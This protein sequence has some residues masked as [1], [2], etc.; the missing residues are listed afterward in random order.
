MKKPATKAETPGKEL[1]VVLSGKAPTI[2]RVRLSKSQEQLLEVLRDPA[3]QVLDISKICKLAN[4]TRATYYNA[5]RDENFKKVYE[6][7]M[8]IYRD[9]NE[10]QMLHVLVEKGKEG[11][12]H[13]YQHMFWKMQN[14]LGEQTSKPALVQVNFN[15]K[16]PDVK[17]EKVIEVEAEEVE[18]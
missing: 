15:V 3:C 17:I 8:Q 2:T 13:N 12:N 14:R 10:F 9:M 11:K 5:F 7:E 6:E 4:V 16:R 1:T 18:S